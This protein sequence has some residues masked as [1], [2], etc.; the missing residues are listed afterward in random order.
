[1]KIFVDENIP[2]MTVRELRAM[3]HDV[4]DIRGTSVQGAEDCDLWPMAQ[5]EGRLLITTD[6]GF[7]EHRNEAHHGILIIC[8]KQPNRHKIHQRVIQAVRRYGEKE[9]PGL[10]IK[11]KD[12]VQ[13]IW[14]S[15]KWKSRKWR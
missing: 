7:S 6:K 5:Q 13:T 9:W 3:G 1:M 14:K 11:M 8:L 2:A 15:R 12:F 4:T 10:M